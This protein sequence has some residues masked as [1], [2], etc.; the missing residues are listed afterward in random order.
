MQSTLI[1]KNIENIKARTSRH[2][3][4]PRK[5][6]YGPFKYV[7]TVRIVRTTEEEP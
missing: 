7:R 3:E 2:K 4:Q 1:I 6:R 5:I